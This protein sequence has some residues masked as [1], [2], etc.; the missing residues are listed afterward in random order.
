[1][2]LSQPKSKNPATKFIDWSGSKGQFKYYDKEAGKDVYFEKEIYIV[3]LDEFSTIKGFHDASTSGIFSNEVRY[4]KKDILTVRAFKGGELAKGLY[5]DIKGNLQ[6]GKFA[7]STYAVLVTPAGKDKTPVLELVNISFYGSALGSYIDSKIN[8]DSGQ[9]IK[10]SPST[11]QKKKGQTIYFEPK[12]EKQKVRKDILESC[13]EFDLQLQKYM[14]SYL[15]QN[16]NDSIAAE[17]VKPNKIVDEF[18][19]IINSE[20]LDADIQ[21]VTEDDLPF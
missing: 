2:S 11:D 9:I 5:S 14:K 20:F 15:S 4:L 12:I 10:L 21:E 17:V 7:R 3:P 8:V 19:S 1:M 18:D 16:E 6:G 13:I